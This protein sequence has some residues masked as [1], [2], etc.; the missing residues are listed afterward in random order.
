MTSKAKPTPEAEIEDAITNDRMHLSIKDLE[1][2]ASIGRDTPV[3]GD[4][5]MVY[6]Q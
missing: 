2:L 1:T 6:N 5:L 4:A 3:S